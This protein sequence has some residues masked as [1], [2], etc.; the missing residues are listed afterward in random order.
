M[1]PNCIG[2][3]ERDPR[4]S[5][6]ICMGERV[7]VCILEIPMFEISQFKDMD[8]LLQIHRCFDSIKVAPSRLYYL[9]ETATLKILGM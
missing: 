5:V 7:R 8:I 4:H 9:R 6:L 2:K 1:L 3:G